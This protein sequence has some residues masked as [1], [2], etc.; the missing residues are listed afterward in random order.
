MGFVRLLYWCS[1]AA[2]VVC[3]SLFGMFAYVLH[4]SCV[5]FSALEHYQANK[6]S[7]VLDDAGREL[8]RFC[9]DRRECISYSIMPKHL[10]EAFVAAEDHQFFAHHGLS[11]RGIV[12][13]LLVNIY[14]GRKAQ[15]ASTITQQLVRLL[16]FDARK[17][18]AR[19]IKEQIYAVLVEQQYTK[20]QI[21][22]AYLNNAYFGCGIY[23]VEAASQRFWS[24]HAAQLTLEEA[25]TLAGI[26]QLPESYCPLTY[27]LSA[28]KRRDVIIGQMCKLGFINDH[29]RLSALKTTVS[30]CELSSDVRAPHVREALRTFLEKCVGSHA[31]YCGGF[32]IQSTINRG[33][34]GAAERA[35]AQ[36]C[37]N[38]RHTLSKDVDGALI[39]IDA[40]TGA[41]KGL[42]GGYDFS[43]SKLN[44]ALQAH[45]QMGSVFKI[46]IYAAAMLAGMS[47]ADTSIDE[48]IEIVQGSYVWRPRNWNRQHNGRMTLAH[49]LSRSNNIVAVKTLLAVGLE[50]VIG[51]AQRCRIEGALHPYPSLALGCVDV[52]PK[53][54][55]GSFNV[56]ANNGVYVEPYM[57]SWI[58]DDLGT[59]IWHHSDIRTRVLPATVSGKVAK[60]L[61]IGMER[62]KKIAEPMPWLSTDVISK[63]GTTNESR[64]C[65][66][67]GATPSLTT[68]VYIG[69]DDNSSMG[70]VYPLQTAF[71]VWKQF[72]NSLPPQRA[73]FTYDA[74]LELVHIDEFTG[75]HVA[76]DAVNAVAIYV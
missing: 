64:T 19:K 68:A 26:V 70:E 15:G 5:D 41:I 50:P 9:L 27:P 4:N 39:S 22:E 42:V 69:C 34:Q 12:R 46:F 20:E 38:V 44:R 60:A 33:V 58:K 74:T 73:H 31:L 57:V 36:Q 43:S 3:A 23:G 6:G 56:F 10:I 25:A 51:L 7:I 52:T 48:P 71:P 55:V 24:K 76:P 16:F 47:F 17:T 18:F 72:Y 65:W 21:L 53:E 40:A 1:V 35:F 2:I 63:T 28:K 54:V 61:N 75:E 49:A 11:W 13:S 32:T 8:M 62:Y 14:R 29:E 30:V 59:K 45:R 67:V 37:A 66:F